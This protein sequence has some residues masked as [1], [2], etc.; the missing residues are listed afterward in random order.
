MVL[1]M[2]LPFSIYSLG[3]W[4]AFWTLFQL[5]EF[6]IWVYMIVMAY[7]GKVVVLPV[8]GPIAQKQAAQ[9]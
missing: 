9:A 8:I 6:G 5:A 4:S 1:G 2:I 3:L 7:N